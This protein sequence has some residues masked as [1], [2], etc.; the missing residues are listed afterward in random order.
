MG[1]DTAQPVAHLPPATLRICQII[2]KGD[3]LQ[4]EAALHLAH[5]RLPE[6][7]LTVSRWG[8]LCKTAVVHVVGVDAHCDRALTNRASSWF[9]TLD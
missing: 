3:G 9:I 7:V 1:P 6:D 5:G 4:T 8:R 2:V